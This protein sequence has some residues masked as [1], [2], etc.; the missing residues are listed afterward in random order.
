MKIDYYI[1]IIGGWM[2]EEA[3]GH[4]RTLNIYSDEFETLIDTTYED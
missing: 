4:K 1:E 2:H 3:T